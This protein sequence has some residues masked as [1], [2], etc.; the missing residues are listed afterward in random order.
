MRTL[1]APDLQRK[2]K[3]VPGTRPGWL[4]SALLFAVAAGVAAHG[5]GVPTITSIAPSGVEL[6]AARD[7]TLTVNGT[8]FFAGSVVQVN[9]AGR[10]TAFVSA[11]QITA[12]IPATDIAAQGTE[13]I[14]VF[15]PSLT[16]P[17]GTSAPFSLTVTP[18]AGAPPVLTS[19]APGL[20]VQGAGRLQLTLQGANFRPGAMVVISPKLASLANSNGHT[21]AADIAVLTVNRIS[22]A[23]MT[24]TVSLSLGATVGL[25]AIDVLN[26]DGT[27]T[28]TLIG[29]AAAGSGTTQ[30]LQISSSTSIGAPVS[31]LNLALLHPRDGTVVSLGGELYA[32]AVMSGA[33][34]GTI[35]GQWLWDNRVVEQFAVNMVCRA[36]CHRPRTRQPLPTWFLGGHTV[37]L[38]M[39]QPSQIATRPVTVVVNP[40]GWQL[41]EA[42][43][44]GVWGSE[45]RFRTSCNCCGRRSR[46]R[47]ATRLDSRRSLFSLRSRIGI[48]PT[49]I[50]GRSLLKFGA[51]NLRAIFTGRFAPWT[52]PEQREKAAANAA[53][54]RCSSRTCRKAPWP[55]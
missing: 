31:V 45:L 24:A 29:P 46:G 50:T 9:G 48:T 13:Q 18:A 2:Q 54:I 1:L 35:I 34:T 8:G 26:T 42:S 44:A 19:A 16:F 37:Q 10:T 40:A 49:T 51:S 38:R 20:A 33:G 12:A 39:Q 25:R 41:E 15:N 11:T 36:E 7:S 52:A 17:G 27:S 28:A 53:S 4:L 55:P 23:L 43:G 21:Q 5:Q 30:P 47:C 3:C 32:E 14:T 6:P 22:T